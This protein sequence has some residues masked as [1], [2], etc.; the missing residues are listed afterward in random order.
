MCEYKLPTGKK[1]LV[2]GGRD[3]RNEDV[4]SRALNAVSST[5]EIGII[6]TG[7]ATGA[8]EV[9]DQWAKEKGIQRI[10][11]PAPW[12]GPAGRWAGPMRNAFMLTF[13]PE[14]MIAFP[15]G[16]GTKNMIMQAHKQGIMV[17][18]F[19]ITGMKVI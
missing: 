13:K 18:K 16:A 7:G 14:L 10:I 11:C 4:I 17:Y 3:Y 5:I 9:A 6:I 8:D 19:D 15:G 2:C 1:V 12:N